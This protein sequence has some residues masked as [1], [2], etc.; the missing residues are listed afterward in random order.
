MSNDRLLYIH[1]MIWVRYVPSLVIERGEWAFTFF[2]S[3]EARELQFGGLRVLV[4][5]V[6]DSEVRGT[7]PLS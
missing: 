5:L 2:F 6:A 3:E 4:A 7:T 1:G